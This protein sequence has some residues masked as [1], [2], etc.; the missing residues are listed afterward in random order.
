MPL[1]PCLLFAKQLF[2]H[3]KPS[4]D[5]FWHLDLS[6]NLELILIFRWVGLN[7]LQSSQV[8]QDLIAWDYHLPSHILTVDLYLVQGLNMLMTIF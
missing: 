6:L 2:A 5:E 1:P 4:I 8:V 3:S 7:L